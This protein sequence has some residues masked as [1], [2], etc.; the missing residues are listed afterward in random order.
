[1]LRTGN[2]DARA[3]MFAR[4]IGRARKKPFTDTPATMIYRDD[5][6]GHSANRRAVWEI[7]DEFGAD[8]AD[9]LACRLCKEKAASLT[10][11]PMTKS[12]SDIRFVRWVAKFR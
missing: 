4:K 7:G 9:D 5:E 6:S 8:E 3:V 2:F 12:I 1:M 10:M 11:K